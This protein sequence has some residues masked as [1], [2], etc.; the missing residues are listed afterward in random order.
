[1]HFLERHIDYSYEWNVWALRRRALAL[2]NLRGKLTHGTQTALT[3][4]KRDNDTQV[5]PGFRV[6]SLE[7]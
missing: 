4:F 2:A 5:R 7:P 1:M 3:H 6:Y